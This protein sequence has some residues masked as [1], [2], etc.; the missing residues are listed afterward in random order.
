[1]QPGVG[2]GGNAVLTTSCC[3]LITVFPQRMFLC[4]P[5]YFKQLTLYCFGCWVWCPRPTTLRS[6]REPATLPETL[7]LWN[8]APSSL[9]KTRSKQPRARPPRQQCWQRPAIGAASSNWGSVLAAFKPASGGDGAGIPA[10]ICN[11]CRYTTK[12]GRQQR[13]YKYNRKPRLGIP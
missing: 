7:C 6:L 4:K 9:L 2:L 3:V 13:V 5:C 11:Y 8:R 1:M 12:H 10:T